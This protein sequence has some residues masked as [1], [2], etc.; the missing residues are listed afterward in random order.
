[1]K[2]SNVGNRF[3][4]NFFSNSFLF[5]REFY[6]R[7]GKQIVRKHY[8]TK[9]KYFDVRAAELPVKR[10][11]KLSKEIKHIVAWYIHIK[12][13]ILHFIVEKLKFCE[14]NLTKIG[15]HVDIQ[16]NCGF[17]QF[18]AEA[19]AKFGRNYFSEE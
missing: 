7:H 6:Q 5:F 14:I 13:Q 8:F 3:F 18:R 17:S 11:V 19:M 4:E 16:W 1:M 15:F 10:L 2:F 12:I 9:K